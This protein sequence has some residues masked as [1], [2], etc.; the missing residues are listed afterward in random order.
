MWRSS[1]TAPPARTRFSTAPTRPC[2]LL[3]LSSKAPV[4]IV[5]YP[6][7]SKVGLWTR[8]GGYQALLR[9]GPELDYWDGE[10]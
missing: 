10:S 7:S 1:R 5:H 2:R 6:D 9:N 4:S 8:G 3:I